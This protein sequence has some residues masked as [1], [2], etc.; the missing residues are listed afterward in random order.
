MVIMRRYALNILTV[1]LLLILTICDTALA[2]ERQVYAAQGDVAFFKE[3]GKIGLQA[4][5]G[6][7]LHA[8]EFDGV[9][10]FDA[11]Q[12]ANI[13]VDDKVGRIDRSGKIIVKPFACD[14]IEAIPTNCTSEAVPP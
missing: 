8:A 4:T 5:D 10:Y 11:T 7:V 13:Y 6:N 9:G 1:F 3:N 14:E 12:Q 2:E